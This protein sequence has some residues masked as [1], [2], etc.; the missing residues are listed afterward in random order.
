MDQGVHSSIKAR[1]LQRYVISGSRFHPHSIPADEA[2][3]K[4]KFDTYSQVFFKTQTAGGERA[5]VM[6]V[7]TR[8]KI[9]K[10]YKKTIYVSY[11]YQLEDSANQSYEKGAWIPERQLES[12]DGS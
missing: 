1:S 10:T 11:E 6:T 7:R 2:Q 5:H 4:A 9:E 3:R 12:S 8:R